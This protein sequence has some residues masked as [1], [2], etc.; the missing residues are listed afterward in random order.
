MC[1]V[2]FGANFL[3]GA[4]ASSRNPKFHNAVHVHDTVVLNC[5]SDSARLG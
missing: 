2:I 3:V 1:L 4:Q 5:R